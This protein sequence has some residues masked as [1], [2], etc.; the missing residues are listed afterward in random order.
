MSAKQVKNPPRLTFDEVFNLIAFAM[1]GRGTCDRLRTA[2][3]ICDKNNH[4][5]GSGYN[6]SLPGDPHCDDVG[7]EMSE[8]HC[9][10][11]NHGE[12]NAIFNC[13]ETE[14]I[15]GGTVTVIGTPCHGCAKKIA[16]FK[17]ARIRYIGKYENAQNKELVAKLCERRGI[18]IEYV[19]PDE[20]I[21]ELQKLLNFHQGPGGLLK[22]LPKTGLKVGG[23]KCAHDR[24]EGQV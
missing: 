14:R 20:I 2:T 4:I 10:R 15:E 21:I 7:H 18:A 16:R 23:C 24:M 12:E 8:G 19:N 13:Y 1:A 6:G 11:T 22:H 9:I 3:I 5:V 17:P